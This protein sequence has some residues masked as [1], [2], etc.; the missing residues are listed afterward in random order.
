MGRGEGGGCVEIFLIVF[1]WRGWYLKKK[2]EV[3]ENNMGDVLCFVGLW[4][5]VLFGR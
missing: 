1:G 2:E 4:L 3:F 5:L